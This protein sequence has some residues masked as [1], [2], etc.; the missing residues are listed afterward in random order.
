MHRYE[1]P[2]EF[3][4][5]LLG[6][7][8]T[9][10]S[11]LFLAM[12]EAK[13]REL[14]GRHTYMDTDSIF[15]PPELAPA[16]I[17]YF[18][19]LNPYAL[20]IP[21]LKEEKRDAWFFGISS[22]R[23]VLYDDDGEIRLRDYKLHGLGHLTNPFSSEVDDWQ[24]EIWMDLLTLSDEEIIGKYATFY[25]I[26]KLSV[27]T[28]NIMPRFWSLNKGRDYKEQIKPFNFFLVGFHTMKAK[29]KI[30]KPLAPFSRNYQEIV[31]KPFVDYESGELIEGVRYFKPLSS[32]I[33]QYVMHPEYKFNGNVGFLRRKEVRAD[34]IVY[35][36]KEANNIDEEAI[37]VKKPQIL[38]F[39]R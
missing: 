6:V 10:A 9:S 17:E 34:G 28:A 4:H 20:D 1:R 7:M 21:L 22:K 26:S 38:K 27:S 15:V 2:G 30:I 23:Y 18:Q 19:P 35:I 16:I 32:T 12:A 25:A 39:I 33:L 3:F 5:P 24:G 31:H 37:G 29:K 8:I 11:R 14:G 36:G 13:V